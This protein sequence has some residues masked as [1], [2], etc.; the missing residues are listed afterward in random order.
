MALPIPYGHKWRSGICLYLSLYGAGALHSNYVYGVC[1]RQA[2]RQ[3]L[4]W[5]LQGAQLWQGMV[6]NRS[7]KRLVLH[8]YL[9]FLYRC[10]RVDNR[11]YSKICRDMCGSGYCPGRRDGRDIC[12]D[13]DLQL[14]PYIVY[15]SLCGIDCRNCNGRSGEGHREVLQIYDAAALCACNSCGCKVT[16]PWGLGEGIGF[17][18]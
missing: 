8:L 14:E 15:G 1:D 13:N 9:R 17:S 4:F 6:C 11:L 2:Q 18:F 7:H 10:G 5:R 3:K 16:Y 12:Q